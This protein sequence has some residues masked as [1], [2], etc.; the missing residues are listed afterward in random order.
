ME[1]TRKMESSVSLREHKKSTWREGVEAKGWGHE[2][3]NG[4]GENVISTQASV[5]LRKTNTLFIGLKPDN[6][7]NSAY[8]FINRNDLMIERSSFAKCTILWVRQQKHSKAC[9]HLKTDHYGGFKAF[10]PIR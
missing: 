3:N 5:S 4:K 6:P 9:S 7:L 8:H 2:A 1:S 10:P